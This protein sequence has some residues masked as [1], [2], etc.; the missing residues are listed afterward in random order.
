ML[1]GMFVLMLM[2]VCLRSFLSTSLGGSDA[3]AA[4]L[5]VATTFLGFSAA[6]RRDA[7]FRFE[8]LTA[9]LPAAVART[10]DRLLEL[11]A[12]AAALLVTYF[13]CSLVFDSWRRGI[14]TTGQVEIPLWIP[15]A[16]MALGMFLV[17]VA[18]AER[19]LT[20]HEV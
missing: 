5:L 12:L 18:I 1:F 15:Q 11:L 16:P 9:A 20:T 17:A 3:L 10:V 6:I 13:L 19:L 7:V 14:V 4:Y 8:T 2:E